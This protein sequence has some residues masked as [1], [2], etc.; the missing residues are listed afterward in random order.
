MDFAALMIKADLDPSSL[1][2]LDGNYVNIKAS[3]LKPVKA[4]T[5]QPK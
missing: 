3:D 1:S 2:V 4:E 5:K